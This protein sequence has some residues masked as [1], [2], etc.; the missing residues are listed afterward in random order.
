MR[1]S[2]CDSGVGQV[3]AKLEHIRRQTTQINQII[4]PTPP[5]ACTPQLNRPGTPDRQGP[6]AAFRLAKDPIDFNRSPC[7][8]QS[9]HPASPWLTG[10][11]FLFLQGPQGLGGESWRK[12]SVRA[13]SKDLSKIQKVYATYDEVGDLLSRRKGDGA[14]RFRGLSP[15]GCL[16]W[17]DFTT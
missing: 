4:S 12:S 2:K 16:R 15:L 5:T 9:M 6:S 8:S 11:S 7:L 1:G 14:E 3:P 10:P 17:H 13:R